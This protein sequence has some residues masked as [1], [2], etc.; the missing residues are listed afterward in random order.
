MGASL[1][2]ANNNENHALELPRVW[3]PMENLST[4]LDGKGENPRGLVGTCMAKGKTNRDNMNL[5]CI[6]FLT[7]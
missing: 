4:S 5:I 6:K 7:L 2:F 3:K 1:D